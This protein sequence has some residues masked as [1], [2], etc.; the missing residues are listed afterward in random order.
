MKTMLAYDL[1]L[2]RKG[3][4]DS[5]GESDVVVN[6][7]KLIFIDNTSNDKTVGIFK[8][9]AGREIFLM[10][11]IRK[12]YCVFIHKAAEINLT[13]NTQVQKRPI[14]VGEERINF[15]AA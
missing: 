15:D 12:M 6:Q 7:V 3:G 1:S 4:Q 10:Y 2:W 5:R 13:H 9:I 8:E 14:V 11:A